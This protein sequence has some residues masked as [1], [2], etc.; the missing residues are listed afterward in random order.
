MNIKNIIIIYFNLFCLISFSQRKY[1]VK[2]WEGVAIRKSPSFDAK[3]IGMLN[4]NHKIEIDEKFVSKSDSILYKGIKI[5]GNWIIYN[6]QTKGYI[7]D[8]FMKRDYDINYDTKLFGKVKSVL[9]Y[10]YDY[11]LNEQP[12]KNRSNK[13][14]FNRKGKAVK[15]YFFYDKNK[16]ILT[17]YKYSRNKLVYKVEGIDSTSYIYNKE[18]RLIKT[19]EYKNNTL[20]FE[21]NYRY[22][23]KGNKTFEKNHYV[24]SNE[25]DSTSYKFNKSNKC[26]YEIYYNNT[27][28]SK[29]LKRYYKYK[30]DTI[31]VRT[32]QVI[33]KLKQV[34][35]ERTF[36]KHKGFTYENYLKYDDLSFFK[37]LKNNIEKS[38]VKKFDK[39]KQLIEEQII[40]SYPP[41]NTVYEFTVPKNTLQINKITTNF[42]KDKKLIKSSYKV[43]AV[44]DYSKNDKRDIKHHLT[45]YTENSL[46]NN[47]NKIYYDFQG[48]KLLEI[49]PSSETKYFK[50]TFDKYGN[51][52]KKELFFGKELANV[53]IRKFE[54]FD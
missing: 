38:I 11:L 28:F 2:K 7:F 52:I 21:E 23:S 24:K 14:F 39:N 30:N 48:R 20:S 16:R 29:P 1:T 53:K 3:K 18:G 12:T 27:L 26:V 44:M 49:N 34:I 10:E 54:Y 22:D 35:E 33:G 9:T 25:Q 46:N 4:Y 51:W 6:T 36:K 5:K 45:L 13:I 32:K 47:E 19:L 17:K 15:D 41:K 31:L 37:K 40:D 42:F 50:Y 43:E 8:G